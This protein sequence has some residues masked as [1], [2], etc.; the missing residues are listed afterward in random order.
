MTF[1]LSIINILIILLTLFA[2]TT[3]IHAQ[4]MEELLNQLTGKAQA[5]QRNPAQLA[6]AYQKAIDYLLPL[7]SADDVGSRYNYQITFQDLGSHA[8][9]S[10]AETERQT[11]AKVMIQTLEQAE[12]PATVRHWFVLQLERIGKGESVPAL[13]KMM[14][15]ED[16][17]LCD[18]ARKA[19]EKNPDPSATDAL[20]K[21]LT[22]ATNLLNEAKNQIAA[23]TKA[24]DE[25]QE[26]VNQGQEQIDKV[27]AEGKK[28][29]EEVM[30][31]VTEKTAQLTQA[32]Q[33]A[34]NRAK[35]ITA[36]KEQIKKLQ[37]TIDELKKKATPAVP[38]LPG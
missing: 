16:K 27:K 36:L 28:A 29:I 9:R 2:V 12:M 1:R 30:K 31:T 21:E 4:D 32:N 33:L 15:S 18:Y 25:L 13:T 37:A 34:E 26:Q 35:E 19:L 24:W 7:M 6:Q 5:P 23:I 38:S 3:N 22:N 14:S 8:S 11:L 10:G 17:H 20:L